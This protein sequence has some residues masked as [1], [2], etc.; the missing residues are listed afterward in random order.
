MYKYL[1]DFARFVNSPLLSYDPQVISG[2]THHPTLL[3]KAEEYA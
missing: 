3:K 2:F 1:G